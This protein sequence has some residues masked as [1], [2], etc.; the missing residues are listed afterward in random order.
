M[1]GRVSF[2]SLV[3]SLLLAASTSSAPTKRASALNVADCTDPGTQ[4]IEHD[5]NVALLGVSTRLLSLYELVVTMFC[6]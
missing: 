2:T 5:C 4:L 3:V 6:Y 1:L